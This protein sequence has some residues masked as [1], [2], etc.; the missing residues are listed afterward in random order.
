MCVC[1][2][3]VDVN[4]K[5]SISVVGGHSTEGSIMWKKKRKKKTKE[6]ED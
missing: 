1:V 5:R 2:F 6:E 4:V 3:V